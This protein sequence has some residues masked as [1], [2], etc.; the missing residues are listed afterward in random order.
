MLTFKNLAESCRDVLF[1]TLANTQEELSLLDSIQQDSQKIDQTIEVY[2][3]AKTKELDGL[4]TEYAKIDTVWQR[5]KS[6]EDQIHTA[7]REIEDFDHRKFCG[8]VKLIEKNEVM[9]DG[10]H[11]FTNLLENY[12]FEDHLVHKDLTTQ[13]NSLTSALG[14]Y[15]NATN[16]IL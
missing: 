10:I 16:S 9:V 13:V 3:A 11:K 14:F 12:A 6:K 4:E 15:Q 8:L 1:N 7:I 2:T 5:L